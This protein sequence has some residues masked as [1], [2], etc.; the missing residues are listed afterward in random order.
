[1]RGAVRP[2]V[3]C[4]F[5]LT[6]Q[7]IILIVHVCL[8]RAIRLPRAQAER[9]KVYFY[10]A[11]GRSLCNRSP[12]CCLDQEAWA[13][14]GERGRGGTQEAGA[15]AEPEGLW[16]ELQSLQIRKV[17]ISEFLLYFCFQMCHFQSKPWL[18]M[19][20]WLRMQDPSAAQELRAPFPREG[21][22]PASRGR[23]HGHWR[24]PQAWL[25]I[26]LSFLLPFPMSGNK[27]ADTEL[28][29]WLLILSLEHLF[30]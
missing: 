20:F 19:C 9:A 8:V 16:G 25:L 3:P 22:N 11:V 29:P 13:E 6:S 10:K 14:P 4:S 23:G 30:L 2:D 5:I 7:T 24:S 26:F 28:V 27:E 12:A 21:P 1:M 15:G 17:R 18:R